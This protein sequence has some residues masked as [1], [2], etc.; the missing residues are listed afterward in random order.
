VQGNRFRATAVAGSISSGISELEQEDFARRLLE[1]EKE[2]WEHRV[3]VEDMV[4]RLRKVAEEVRAQEEPHVLTLPAIQ[5]LETVIEATLHPGETVLSVLEDLHPTPAVCGFPREN[6]LALIRR[7][8]PFQRGWYAGP[9]GW[10]DGEGNGVFVPA[11]RSALWTGPEWRLF[12]G[13]GIVRGSDPRQEWEETRI[14]FQPVLEAL[15]VSN[16]P[17][18]AG[19]AGE[20]A[21]TETRR[22]GGKG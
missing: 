16:P 22:D 10:F 5:H 17:A 13:A 20:P 6:A 12:A 19:V 7:E 11:L 9:V 3:S 18:G 8:E 15:A 14:K 21:A 1:S 2:R 4:N